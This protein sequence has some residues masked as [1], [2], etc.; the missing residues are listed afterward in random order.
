MEES[1]LNFIKM[2]FSTLSWPGVGVL[3]AIES[4]CIPLPS[5][6]IMPLAGWM[7][8]DDVGLSPVYLL[9]AAFCGAVGNVI[10]SLI[11]YGVGAKGGVPLLRR[12]GKYILISNHDLDRANLWFAKY[13]N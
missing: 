13:G 4:A 1:I 9:L 12:N 3:M 11:A 2:V 5:E 7:L 10:G 6:L 8:I